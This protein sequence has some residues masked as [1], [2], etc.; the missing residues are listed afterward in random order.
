MSIA[1]SADFVVDASETGPTP[2]WD[3]FSRNVYCLLGTPIDAIGIRDLLRAIDTAAAHKR[4]LLI[5]TANLN[6]LMNSRSDPGFR[7]TLLLSEL[8]T[9]D[10]AA[11]V[12]IA[13][14]IGLP[15]K[16]R[17]AG[18]DLFE[19]LI[20]RS[21]SSH[22][23]RLFLFG[24]PVGAAKA[25]AQALNDRRCGLACV[26]HLYP[27]YGDVEEMSKEPIIS[28]INNSQADLLVAALGAQKGQAWLAR[29][30]DRL[31]VPIRAHLGAAINFAAGN[32]RRAPVLV[33]KLGLEWL[34]RIKEEPHLWT[35]YWHDGRQ[36]LGL[37]LTQITP[38]AAVERWAH[39]YERV[40]PK[41]HVDYVTDHTSV[42]LGLSG[43]ATRRN[44]QVISAR[45]RDIASPIET[46]RIN[47]AKTSMIDARFLGLLLMLNK[48]AKRR[49][50]ELVLTD[51]S[52]W[53]RAIFRLNGAEFLLDRSEG[54]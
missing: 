32:I 22:R 49:G 24:G 36:L 35:R 31:T 34:W 27:G 43:T 11:V 54:V 40:C 1:V 16:E 8:C 41:L 29:N 5:S 14:L 50:V 44:V 39:L 45:L 18:A 13:R 20:A 51:A 9:A 37:L 23:L 26:G 47:L 38:L 21:P 2:V 17:V 52:Y 10:G 3:D 6:F 28:E 7:K 30:N 19:R 25:A 33:R 4:R 42:R 53:L 15:I 46:V 12:W 48:E